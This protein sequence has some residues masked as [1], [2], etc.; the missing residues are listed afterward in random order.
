MLQFNR[1]LFLFT[2]LTKILKLIQKTLYKIILYNTLL[3]NKVS[4][5]FLSIFNNSVKEFLKLWLLNE[6]WNIHLNYLRNTILQKF[7]FHNTTKSLYSF[8][9][10]ILLEKINFAIL[11]F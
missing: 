4:W 2:K 9:S 6:S 1:K 5:S 11:Y 3:K 10:N 8:Y 7:I